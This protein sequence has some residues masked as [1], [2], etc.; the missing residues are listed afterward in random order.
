MD[1]LPIALPNP[2]GNIKIFMHRM[3]T[4][5]TGREP[6]EAFLPYLP[7]RVN[8]GRSATELRVS[9]HLLFS[10]SRVSRDVKCCSH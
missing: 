9:G 1:I 5:W 6:L 2:V 4:A 8:S 7:R 10:A 3:C